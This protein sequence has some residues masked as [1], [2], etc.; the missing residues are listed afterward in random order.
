MG[1]IW[2]V[3]LLLSGCSVFFDDPP[4]DPPDAATPDATAPDSPSGPVFPRCADIGCTT[5]DALI[6]SGCI[7]MGP[8]GQAVCQCRLACGDVEGPW[9]IW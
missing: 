1:R 9:C 4:A 8:A 3:A 2:L 5:P 7:A 6:D